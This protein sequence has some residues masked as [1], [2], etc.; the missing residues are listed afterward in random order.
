VTAAPPSAASAFAYYAR[1]LQLADRPAGRA[2][3]VVA[4]ARDEEG[5]LL[6]GRAV[7]RAP[8]YALLEEKSFGERLAVQRWVRP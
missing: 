1:E 6:A 7:V 5:L 4:S 8:R 2:I 3:W